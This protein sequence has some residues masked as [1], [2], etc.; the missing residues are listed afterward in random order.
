M[1]N[2]VLFKWFEE[3]RLQCRFG[4]FAFERVRASLQATDPEQTFFYV[5]AW[6]LQACQVSRWF[7][8]VRPASQPRGER[9]RQELRLG[10]DSPIHLR[11]LRN[12]LEA[13]DEQLED[14]IATMESPVYLESNIMPQGSL[15]AFK[16]DSFQRNLDPDTYKLVFRGETLDL[17]RLAEELHRLES[18]IQIWLRT[19]NPW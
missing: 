7:W 2:P 6:L 15:S 14:W 12:R 13:A 18:A 8:P 5:Q 10:D 19:H 3:I 11:E 17:R 1:N 4:K 9:L 16:Q